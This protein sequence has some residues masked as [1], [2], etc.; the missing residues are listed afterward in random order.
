MI[1]DFVSFSPRNPL[2]AVFF[3]VVITL[4]TFAMSALGVLEYPNGILYDL[5]MR[6]GPSAQT[7]TDDV[8]VILAPSGDDE[9]LSTQWSAALTTL[10]EL[11]AKQIIFSTPPR[12][13]SPEFYQQARRLGNVTFGRVVH[14]DDEGIRIGA[15]PD[16]AADFDLQYGSVAVPPAIHG[17]HRRQHATLTIDGKRHAVLEWTAAY[18]FLG[19]TAALPL[20][21]YLVNFQGPADRLPI[22][23]MRRLL[24]QGLIPELVRDRNVIIGVDSAQPSIGLHTPIT[25]NGPMLPL[26]VF[27]GYALD[28]LIEQRW[29]RT[30]PLS[31]VLLIIA[32]VVI[33]N[34]AVYQWIQVRFAMGLTF[35]LIA[36]YLLVAWVLPGYALYWPPISEMLVAQASS[37]LLVMRH[38][39]LLQDTTLRELLTDTTARLKDS[40]APMFF[41]AQQP[42]Q[43]L[44]KLVLQVFELDR[45]VLL[46]RLTDEER[47]AP[48]EFF[49]CSID[50]IYEQR[51]DY[52][53]V[54]YATAIG[55]NRP[56]ALTRSFLTRQSGED[57]FLVPLSYGGEIFGFWAFGVTSEKI[58]AMPRFLHV[59]ERISVEISQLLYDR[60]RWRGQHVVAAGLT[61]WLRLQGGY[62]P[63][64][65]LRQAFDAMMRRVETLGWSFHGINAAVVVFDLFGDP[66]DVNESMLGLLENIDLNPRDINASTLITTLTDRDIARTKSILQ[67]VVLGGKPLSLNAAVAGRKEEYLLTIHPIKKEDGS[68]VG[69]TTTLEL[70]GILVEV[71]DVT[72]L[73]EPVELQEKALRRLMFQ[74]RNDLESMVLAAGLLKDEQLPSDERAQVV[75]IYETKVRES[76]TLVTDAQQ[77]LGLDPDVHQLS[78]YPVHPT[79][80]LRKAIQA[81]AESLTK[82]RIKLSLH[83]PAPEIISLVL[84]EPH[85]LEYVLSTIIAM[86]V[87]DAIAG[88]KL[89][90]NL[91][92]RAGWITFELAN[93]GFGIPNEHFQG[94]LSQSDDSTATEFQALRECASQIQS[95]EGTFAGHS[96][97][98][99]GTR[100]RI[101]LRSFLGMPPADTP[102][103]S[104][105]VAS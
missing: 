91:E 23:S 19:G 11:G 61:R 103:A 32:F 105:R 59:V 83:A 12:G 2:A 45:V 84:A 54:P 39:S 9:S 29:I 102:V 25:G 82:Q 70:S 71:V 89:E 3:A 67:H 81:A 44:M 65:P 64:E 15:W 73:R 75:D 80:S 100:F 24:E 47:V 16:A 79:D 14:S 5:T 48:V 8:V 42:F 52:R 69:D 78:R 26:A 60:N 38:K 4:A 94:Y 33:A 85:E 49:G 101:E 76:I 46:Q 88:S 10:T 104:D 35:G 51:R 27:Q 34:L 77:H 50:D 40:G 1:A 74:I 21:S 87:E 99:T 6:F 7:T 57:Q 18:R 95:W 37:F 97:V 20:E 53:R 56:I 22:I 28:T 41:A 13:G 43:Q 98:G 86:L 17:S 31:V 55:E 58:H 63:R 30:T 66:L 92:E 93:Q 72:K 90:I 62:T 96:E 68:Q 36:T